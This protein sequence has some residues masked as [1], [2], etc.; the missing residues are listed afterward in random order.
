ME[1]DAKAIERAKWPDW[2]LRVKDELDMHAVAGSKGKWAIFHLSDGSPFDHTPYDTWNDA[3]K[4]TKWDRDNFAYVEIQ[5][6]GCP[7]NEADA[8]LRYARTIHQ[9]G[10][11]IPTPDWEAGPMVASMP[12]NRHDRRRMAAQ[13]KKG[14]ALYPED[15]PYGNLPG[16]VRKVQ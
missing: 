3:V 11:R 16:Q 14:R 1:M 4:A 8:L 15:M 12:R 5:P 13:L 6:D 10:H 9:L 2:T 7:Y